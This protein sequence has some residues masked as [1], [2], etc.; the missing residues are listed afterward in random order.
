M[1]KNSVNS[2]KKDIESI[3]N[4]FKDTENL[5]EDDFINPYEGDSEEDEILD[6][7][8]EDDSLN[9]YYAEI[10]E[11]PVFEETHNTEN[12]IEKEKK[13]DESVSSSL[14]EDLLEGEEFYGEGSEDQ[15]KPEIKGITEEVNEYIYSKM[16]Y[17][18]I[19]IS[20]KLSLSAAGFKVLKAMI[21][22]TSVVDRD[23][24]IY[25]EMEKG[26]FLIGCISG[27]QVMNFYD[28]VGL[29]NVKVFLDRN[30]ELK[31]DKKYVLC[32]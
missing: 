26:I 32:Q 18:A 23:I 4:E 27:L 16:R 10:S 21:S 11:T 19:F 30:I 3:F 8:F 17:P 15:I 24:N 13:V 7:S 31:G 12:L 22:S 14:S 2:I 5:F 28:L 9:P 1:G 25:N 29:D 6:N 20:S